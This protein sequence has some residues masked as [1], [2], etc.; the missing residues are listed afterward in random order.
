MF[1]G[2]IDVRQ[3]RPREVNARVVNDINDLLKKQHSKA[4]RLNEDSL[5]AYSKNN[6]V[7]VAWNDNEHII[8]MGVLIVVD[9]ASHEYGVVHHLTVLRGADSLTLRAKIM[10]S[11]ITRV[12]EVE[13]F[14]INILP[15]D[16]NAVIFLTSMGFTQR[17]LSYRLSSAC[18]LRYLKLSQEQ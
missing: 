12:V 7:V 13:F 9:A 18:A 3:L 1:T 15:T 8:G 16:R 6:K 11:L 14:M 17:K 10:E 2:R 4:R 5:A